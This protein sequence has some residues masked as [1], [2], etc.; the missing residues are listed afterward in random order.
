[1]TC[2]VAVVYRHGVMMGADSMR[3]DSNAQYDIVKE[4]KVWTSGGFL[5]SSAGSVRGQQILR[6]NCP[7]PEVVP[8]NVSRFLVNKW[9]PSVHK[10][11]DA[12]E[13]RADTEKRDVILEGELL[14]ATPGR[15]FTIDC[16]LGITEA[17]RDHATIGSGATY[18]LGSLHATQ[19]Q[20]PRDRILGALRAAQANC[21]TVKAPFRVRAA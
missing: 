21:A 16:D 11:F 18:A 13:Y 19:G 2:C 14:V 15:L 6:W 1:M 3:S 7:F 20:A 4:S 5:I 9:L 17:S 8:T 10:A 12:H